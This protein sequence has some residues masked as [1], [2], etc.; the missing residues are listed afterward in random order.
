MSDA[1]RPPASKAAMGLA[2]IIGMAALAGAAVAGAVLYANAP[3]GD[4]LAQTANRCS[5]REAEAA[6]AA[7]LA[8]GDVAAMAASSPRPMDAVSFLDASG[9]QKSLADFKG[10]T[11]LLNL[12]ATWCAPCREEMPALDALQAQ[13][14]SKAFEVVALNL[15]RGTDNK[16][17]DFY[18]EIGIEHLAL[19]RD[20]TLKSFNDLKGEGLVLGLPVTMLIDRDGCLLAAMNGPAHWSGPD[21]FAFVDGMLS[22]AAAE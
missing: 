3:R 13:R 10:K 4:N 15:D 14:G 11:V 21:A 7:D 5:G 16:P 1:P 20:G 17:Q 12:W 6:A 8:T 9:A 22:R 18:A 2:R 19:Y